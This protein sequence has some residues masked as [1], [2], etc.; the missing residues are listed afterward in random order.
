M[1]GIEFERNLKE[2]SS[3]NRDRSGGTLPDLGGREADD[4]ASQALGS[5]SL[6]RLD[7]IDCI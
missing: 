5:G 7:L 2:L 4:P 6:S 3:R 1:G